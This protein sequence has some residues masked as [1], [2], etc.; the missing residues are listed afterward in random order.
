MTS[1][2][3]VDGSPPADIDICV[4]PDTL[5]TEVSVTVCHKPTS[6]MFGWLNAR[7]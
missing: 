4:V 5:Q 2:E 1:T 6:F 7:R 3:I